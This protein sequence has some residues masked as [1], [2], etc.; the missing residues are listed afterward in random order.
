M[1]ILILVSIIVLPPE[2]VQDQERQTF[3]DGLA[4]NI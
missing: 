4:F 1:S 3:V 2:L